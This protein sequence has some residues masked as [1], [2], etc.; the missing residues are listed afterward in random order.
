MTPGLSLPLA[1]TV[2]AGAECLA[3]SGGVG[4]AACAFVIATLLAQKW[5]PRLADWTFGHVAAIAICATVA[6]QFG[7]INAFAT[8][9]GWLCAHR[10]VVQSGQRDQRILLLLST[11]MVLVGS[12]GSLSLGL[13]PGLV[14]FSFAT[15]IAFLRAFGISARKLEIALSV[16]TS[17]LAVGFFILVPRLQGSIIGGL[18]EDAQTNDFADD[19][20][21]GDETLDPNRKAMV[22]RAH[23]W[24]RDGN[25]LRGPMYFRGAAF[26]TFD[27]RAWSTSGRVRRAS[28]GTWDVRAEIILEPMQGGLIFGPPDTLYAKAAGF[29]VL[30]RE[31]GSLDH[32]QPGRR[33]SYEVFSRT[34]HLETIELR[35]RTLAKLPELD[36][37]ILALA[38]SIAPGE[39]DP[40]QISAAMTRWFADGFTYVSQP[41]IPEGDPL[42]WFLLDSHT[43]H[44]EYFASGLAVLL[45]ARHVPARLATG[46]YSG[47]YNEAGGYIAVRRGHAH[48]WVEVPVGGGWAVLDATPVGDLPNL[49]V[50]GWQAFEETAT[51]A[52]LSVV[53]DYDLK[54]Q[55][56]GLSW[57]GSYVIGPGHGDELTAQSRTGLAGAAV[58]LI[59]LMGSGTLARLII[60]WLARPPRR[61]E[62]TDH[63]LA[64][65]AR[66]RSIVKKRG[67]KLPDD[68]PPVEAAA[69]LRA[70]AGQEAAALEELAWVVYRARYAGV[71]EDPKVVSDL[72]ARIQNMPK[73]A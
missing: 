60:W 56:E 71:A 1:I 44:C 68:L 24:D 66:A 52:W 3:L 50:S 26:D 18:G 30:Q 57:L 32:G 20:T 51:S 4:A 6:S 59:S 27:G 69:W 42:S 63:L 58:V 48:A 49:E 28:S 64:A 7:A 36:P 11:L 9:L 17:V 37:R 72:L 45:R 65:F 13:V 19:V 39:T 10:I 33:V 47:E 29:P 40:V 62:N 22:L 54:T 55:F 12:V 15:P 31:D 67:W 70:E 8:L 25:A 21:L 43:G 2:L 41:P 61:V 38:E 35:S 53:L 46:F 23:A 16:S 14:A 5:V 34:R 73:A